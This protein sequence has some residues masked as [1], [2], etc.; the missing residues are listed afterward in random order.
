MHLPLKAL[1]KRLLPAAD[2]VMFPFVYPAA[3]LMWVVRRAGVDRLPW[4]RRALM[5]VGVFPIRNHYFEP[6][7]DARQLRRPL[8]AERS[9]PG[10]DWNIAEQLELLGR[11]DHAQ[12]LAGTPAARTDDLTYH[13]DS[14]WFGPGDAEFLYSIIRLKKPRRIVEVGSGLSTLMAVRAVRMNER[15]DPGYRCEHTCVEPF[16]APWLERAGV[17]VIRRR[18]EDLGLPLFQGLSEND[19]LFIDSSHVIR[20]QGDV[21]FEYLE[22]LPSLRRGVIV[23]VHDV[24]SP[25]DYPDDWVRNRVKL[26]NEQYLVEAFLTSNRE[27][28]IVGALNMLRHRHYDRLRAKCPFLTAE[29]EPSSLYIQKIA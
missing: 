26:W 19:L 3:A 23:H 10:I 27:W 11:F 29:S 2:A 4:C 21:V 7:F 9:L 6:L 14:I 13:T 24:F 12:E 22:L 18:V 28:K 5:H 16:E 20:P 15:D 8:D 17:E 25:R 1:L